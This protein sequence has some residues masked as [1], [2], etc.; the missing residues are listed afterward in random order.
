MNG[1]GDVTEVFQFSRFLTLCTV[2]WP[3][4]S[5]PNHVLLV[6][7]IVT[8]LSLAKLLCTEVKSGGRLSYF[9]VCFFFSIFSNL[10]CIY[11]RH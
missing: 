2:S 9:C 11:N 3:M 7:I 8:W 5:N 10:W 1:D 4:S 6:T